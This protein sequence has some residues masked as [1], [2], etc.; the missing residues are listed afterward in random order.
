MIVKPHEAASPARDPRERA[1]AAAERQTA[2]YLHRKFRSDPDVCVLHQLRIEDAQQ[3]EQS[4]ASGVCQIDHLVVHR[5]GFFLIESKS[6]AEAVRVRPDADGG[7]E[8]TRTHRGE[9]KGIPSPIGQAKRQ[10]EFLRSVLERHRSDLLSRHPAGLR[11]IAR[12]LWQTDG[13]SFARAPMQLAIAVSDRGRIHRSDGWQAPQK[14]FRVF[15]AKADLVPDK[16]RAELDRHR[17]GSKLVRVWPAG[18]YGLWSMEPGEVRRVAEFLVS[19][20]TPTTVAATAPARRPSAAVKPDGFSEIRKQY[21]NAYKPW[22]VDD[23]RELCRLHDQGREVVDLAARFGR[24]P[25]AIR[26]RLRHLG[27]G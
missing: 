4:G 25:G 23:D 3:P 13:R 21:P 27:R 6:V 15:V 10:S 1:G 17:S 26:S 2:H 20:H 8:W 11:T 24:Q 5:W 16:I 12:I 18:D 7:D 22:P 14:P 19:R 9:E